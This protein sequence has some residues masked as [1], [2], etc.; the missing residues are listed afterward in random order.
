MKSLILA[1]GYATRMYP[2]TK[3][4]PK[5]LLEVGRRT[6][7]DR[8]IED[9][10]K[11]DLLSQHIIVTNNVFYPYFMAWKSRSHYRKD[12]IIVNDGTN[13]SQSGD[14]AARSILYVIESLCV[15]E[16]LLVVSGDSVVTFSFKDF[17]ISA[18]GKGTTCVVS[19]YETCIQVLQNAGVMITDSTLKV[20]NFFE[21]PQVPPSNWVVLPF[22]FFKGKDLA[23]ISKA[24]IDG[25]SFNDP[26]DIISRLCRQTDVYAWEM[27]G[28]R[29]EVNDMVSYE[30]ICK[31]FENI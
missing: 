20:L 8:L 1:A 14:G 23:L 15:D 4:F 16:D 26:G 21:K 2:L 7:L 3:N 22:I 12:I 31:K 30:L 5:P 19:Y 9:L 6:I 13:E 28:K 27:L 17:V 24:M 25:I 11:I 10:D 29:F 18:L